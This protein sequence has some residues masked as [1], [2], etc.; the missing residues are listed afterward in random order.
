MKLTT[1]VFFEHKNSCQ[2]GWPANA[3]W[4]GMTLVPGAS[5][6]CLGTTSSSCGAAAAAAAKQ[7]G[8]KGGQDG[9]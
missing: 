8:T 2:D 7:R 5:T 1:K 3:G 9:N 4:D 6:C